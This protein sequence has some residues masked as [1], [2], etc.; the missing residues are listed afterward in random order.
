MQQIL[1]INSA[2]RE[3][4]EFY[5]SIE[6]ILEELKVEYRSINYRDTGSVDFDEYAGVIITGSPQGDDIVEAH[7]PYFRW[8]K[9]YQKPVIG[10]CA[11]HHVVGY[12][13][14]AEYLRSV[15]PESGTFEIEQMKDDP[16]FEG[17]PTTFDAQQ[18][19]NDSISLP[20]GFTHLAKS[21]VCF[22]Q[23]MKHNEKPLYTFQFHPEYLNR[24]IFRNF[25][26]MADKGHI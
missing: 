16:I 18:M 4:T 20:E 17:L 10:I 21:Q 5:Q 8:V 26:K 7:Q 24:E 13:H 25:C 15:E 2:E 9:N 19:H 11:G 22:N 12:M 3:V 1:I 6:A 23:A 14:G